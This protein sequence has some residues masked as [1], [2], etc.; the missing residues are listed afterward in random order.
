VIKA[1]ISGVNV[2]ALGNFVA[3]KALVAA[4][5]VCVGL[6]FRVINKL[7]TMLV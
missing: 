3:S 5:K 6:G 4:T 2:N 1:Q 7:N